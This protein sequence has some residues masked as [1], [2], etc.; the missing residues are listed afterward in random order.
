M[1]ELAIAEDVVSSV[2]ERT[3]DRDVTVVRLR[4]GAAWR[5]RR[6][7]HARHLPSYDVRPAGEPRPGTAHAP[8]GSRP[9]PPRAC[10]STNIGTEDGAMPANVSDSER[11]TVT[12][13]FAKLVELVNQ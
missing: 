7:G 1:H 10:I 11:A 8:R 9:H 6:G 5:T 3:G 2:R 13:G 12:A 4:V